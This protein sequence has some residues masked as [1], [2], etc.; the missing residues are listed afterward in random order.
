MSESE[1]KKPE[2]ENQEQENK[3][4]QRPEIEWDVF[5]RLQNL[6]AYENV[7]SSCP[8]GSENQVLSDIKKQTD[9]WQEVVN[10]FKEGLESPAT[11]EEFRKLIREQLKE[12]I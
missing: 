10:K 1:N 3:K 9:L 4:E 8:E 7:M 6:P 12:K 2:S 5:K 11:R